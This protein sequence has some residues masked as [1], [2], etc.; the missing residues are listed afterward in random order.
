MTSLRIENTHKMLLDKLLYDSGLECIRSVEES[1]GTTSES[2]EM[3][4]KGIVYNF[5]SF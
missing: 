4:L 1:L 5:T 2:E 3:E